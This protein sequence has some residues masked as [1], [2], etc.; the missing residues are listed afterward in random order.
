MHDD[1]DPEII[2]QFL[3]YASNS[4][5][6]N[7]S[8]MCGDESWSVLVQLAAH[9]ERKESRYPSFLGSR[10][11]SSP[12]LSR[13][14]KQLDFCLKKNHTH[15]LCLISLFEEKTT[16]KIKKLVFCFIW[17][18]INTH[19]VFCVSFLFEEKSTH[20]VLSLIFFEEKS[21]LMMFCLWFCLK[22]NPHLQCFR[23]PFFFSTFAIFVFHFCLKKYLHSQCFVF[24]FVWR[25]IHTCNVLSF[26]LFWKN[27][28]AS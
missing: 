2:R 20:N 23:L 18:K 3:S 21:I 10:L 5:W 8:T 6:K 22:K 1:R 12:A 28:H 17:R 14:W 7:Q 15:C 24:H 26:I 11:S 19:N 9:L 27:F 16:L 4:S 13:Q 25:K